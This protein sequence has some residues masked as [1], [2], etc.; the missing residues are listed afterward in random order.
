MKHGF[1]TPNNPFPKQGTWKQGRDEAAQN[2]GTVAIAVFTF[3]GI[4]LFSA[5]IMV[6]FFY[7]DDSN[8]IAQNSTIYLAAAGIFFGFALFTRIKNYKRIALRKKRQ[9]AYK[10]LPYN[11]ESPWDMKIKRN[12]TIRDRQ[13]K[14]FIPIGTVSLILNV[15]L[16]IFATWWIS[17]TEGIPFSLLEVLAMARSDRQPSAY[18]VLLLSVPSLLLV[19]GFFSF[20]IAAVISLYYSSPYTKNDYKQS[21]VVPALQNKF[22]NMQFDSYQ[23]LDTQWLS[24]VGVLLPFV[25]KLSSEGQ[26]RRL[27]ALGTPVLLRGSQSTSHASSNDYVSGVYRSV[28]FCQSDVKISAQVKKGKKAPYIQ[29][30]SGRWL[31]VES[32]KLISSTFYVWSKQFAFSGKA[33]ALERG[34]QLV[35]LED[36]QFNRMFEVYAEH[37]HDVFY[38][39][40]PPVMSNL[41]NIVTDASG[42]DLSH[43]V[44]VCC[45]G[46]EIHLLVSRVEDAFE[47]D[48]FIVMTED[49]ARTKV[50]NEIAL[51]TDMIDSVLSAKYN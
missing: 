9:N 8:E 21:F 20:L 43:G 50:K 26:G 47:P 7:L 18:I 38:F 46:S 3:I 28:Y 17:K 23:G 41:K 32:P 27:D 1:G 49:M 14:I 33:Q 44:A 4:I 31:V 25:G 22:A 10:N 24:N 15:P 51:I 11:P 30:F 19:T 13:L 12:F 45:R 29:I 2:D 34:L 42:E 37:P 35:M 39:M 5:F 6:E 48:L 40:T 16:F 36:E